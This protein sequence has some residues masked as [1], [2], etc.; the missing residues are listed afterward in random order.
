MFD[1]NVRGFWLILIIRMRLP[2]KRSI[3]DRDKYFVR[4]GE[5][6][7]RYC[8]RNRRARRRLERRTDGEENAREGDRKFELILRPASKIS[9]AISWTGTVRKRRA[10]S[11]FL[12]NTVSNGDAIFPLFLGRH[13]PLPDECVTFNAPAN[14]PLFCVRH[15]PLPFTY[16][17]LERVHAKFSARNPP[18][19]AALHLGLC[20]LARSIATRFSFSFSSE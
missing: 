2:R 20:S 6:R 19:I 9:N 18:D 1:R 15:P 14:S 12:L 5:H 17:D 7:R 8:C 4:S 3:V 13:E 10:V 11:R 16:H